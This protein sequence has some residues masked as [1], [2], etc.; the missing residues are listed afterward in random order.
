MR[1]AW[2]CIVCSVASWLYGGVASWRQQP[3]AYQ[4]CGKHV[5]G[6]MAGCGFRQLTVMASVTS[7]NVDDAARACLWRMCAYRYYRL[8]WRS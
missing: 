8:S 7:L 6:G 2:R 1:M 3:V 5:S 4:R